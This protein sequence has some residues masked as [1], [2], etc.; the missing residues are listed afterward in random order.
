MT[1]KK[2]TTKA[3]KTVTQEVKVVIEHQTP[4]LTET[5]LSEP[6]KEN[7]KLSIAKTWVSQSNQCT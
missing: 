3:K 6:I 1:A 2:T 7:N 5:A 4:V